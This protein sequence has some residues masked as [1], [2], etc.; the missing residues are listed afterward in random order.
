MEAAWNAV[1]IPIGFSS[2]LQ[3]H[4][5]VDAANA[6]GRFQSLSGFQVRCNVAARTT[7]TII[8]QEFQSLSGFQVRC[9]TYKTLE[10][11]S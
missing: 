8:D 7:I 11:F 2:S 5:C 9:N 6:V 10:M 4:A 1:S 3:L